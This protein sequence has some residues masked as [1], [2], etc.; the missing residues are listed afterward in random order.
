MN[1][2]KLGFVTLALSAGL[3]IGCTEDS[4]VAGPVEPVE[5]NPCLNFGTLK[6]TI[7]ES[8]TIPGDSSYS[9]AGMTF[10]KAGVTVTIGAGATIK[11]S[12][13]R[14]VS[15]A[16]IVERGGRLIAEGTAAKPIIFTAGTASPRRGDFG[17][18]VLLGAAPLNVDGGETVIEGTNGVLYGGT[19]STDSSGVLNYVRIEYAG[20]L[21]AQDNELNGLTMG[22]VGSKTRISHVH[23]FEGLDD[24]FE[25]FG[26]SVSASHLVATGCDDDMFDW[27]YGWNGTLQFAFGAHVGITNTDANG[28]EADN[29]G[30]NEQALPRSNPNVANITL[31]GNGTSSLNGMRLRRGTAGKIYNAIVTGFPAGRAVRVDGNNSI[32][33]VMNDSLKGHGIYA[34]NNGGRVNVAPAAGLADSVATVAAAI[35]KIDTS[36]LLA[37]T[38]SLGLTLANPKPATA[39]AGAVTLPTDK[40]FVPATYVG[41]FDPAATTLWINEGV[42]VR[43]Y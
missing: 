6:T 26:G 18:V 20:Y 39:P 29:R 9:L 32:R 43:K 30:T 37:P 21:I 35:A 41:A 1:L 23:Q 12:S 14:N 17:G 8:C 24:C 15:T 34:Y 40:G 25:W 36:W 42:W 33:L 28:I 13:D 31:M 16:F 11:G 5:S 27:D 2:K 22:G 7:T 38:A 3:M 10:V 4:K 19:N